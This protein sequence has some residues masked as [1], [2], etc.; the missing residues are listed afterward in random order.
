MSRHSTRLFKKPAM[1]SRKETIST[2]RS[3]HPAIPNLAQVSTAPYCRYP[4]LR[5][6]QSIMV[7]KEPTLWTSHYAGELLRTLPSTTLKQS[8]NLTMT[9]LLAELRRNV[10]AR[11][12]QSLSVTWVSCWLS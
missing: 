5:N 11:L 4:E 2:E 10:L 3:I 12:L 7:D 8:P 6:Q 1:R 9:P